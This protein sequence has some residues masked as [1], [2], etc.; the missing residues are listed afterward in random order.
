LEEVGR[1]VAIEC[2]S[3][4]ALLHIHDLTHLQAQGKLEYHVPAQYTQDRPPIN[5]SHIVEA[6]PLAEHPLGARIPRPNGK[7]QCCGDLGHFRV[8]SDER[9]NTKL[10]DWIYSDKAQL[11]LEIIN[12]SDATFVT[13]TWL[14]TLL[15]AMGRHALLRAWQAVLEGRDD[16]VPPFIGYD[17]NPF[18][19]L[20][21]EKTTTEEFVLKD[22]QVGKLGLARFVF[23]YM[24]ES[25]WY[26]IDE[27]R[28]ICMPSS[29]FAKLKA[30]AY[31][32]LKT[33]D[34]EQ[35]TFSISNAATPFLSD[36]DIITAFLLPI[37]ARTNP[38][39]ANSAPTRMIAMANVMGM[40][41]VLRN[42]LPPLLPQ[43][44]AYI[45]NCVIPIWSHFTV[46]EYLNLP[47]GHIAAR[48]RKDLVLQSTRAQLDA[49]Q[50]LAANGGILF[51][52]GDMAM[53]TM[54]NWSKAR[55]FETD[56]SA[57]IV[58]GADVQKGIGKPK[59]IHPFATQDGFALR[60]AASCVGRDAEGNWWMGCMMRK[61]IVDEFAKEVGR[62]AEK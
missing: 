5:Y 17:T 55:L 29:Y 61:E 7:L 16:D 24:A 34:K 59:Y 38:S 12:L 56:F 41:D 49:R 15:D 46:D 35:L 13:I 18:A 27:G 37:V 25:Y 54:S 28:M 2:I 1:E 60:N 62:L 30:Q 39:I 50:A 11:G 58:D 23:N 6:M 10:K 51:G 26:P 53:V 14:H 31:A 57:A 22:K 42:T 44:G 45:H 40:R 8:L 21:S 43:H 52:S 33:L 3:T 36:G 20:G 19:D 47:L 4:T 9:N 32:D 48:I